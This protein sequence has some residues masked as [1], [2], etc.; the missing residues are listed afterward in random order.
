M[1]PGCAVAGNPAKIFRVIDE[2][3]TEVFPKATRKLEL[4]NKDQQ[5]GAQVDAKALM[6]R[7]ERLEAELKEV[8]E[9]LKR[10]L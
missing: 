2:S 10:R 3:V 7:M 9:E 4:P 5:C 1:P 6:G 8:K